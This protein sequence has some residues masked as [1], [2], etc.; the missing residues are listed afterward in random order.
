MENKG[1][2]LVIIYSIS[3]ILVIVLFVLAE[4][5]ARPAS[6]SAWFVDSWLLPSIVCWAGTGLERAYLD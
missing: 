2:R 6:A 3:H 4:S 1:S 5:A